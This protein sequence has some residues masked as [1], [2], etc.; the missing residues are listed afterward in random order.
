MTDVGSTKRSVVRAARDALAGIN[1]I[2]VGS[3][4]MAGSEKRGVEHARADL[5]DGAT[6][7]LTPDDET[8]AGAVADIEA[9]W[10]TL[11]MQTVR[12]S[13]EEHD[14]RISD[15]SHLPH[16]LAAALVVMQDPRSLAFAGKG[17]ED[18]TRIAAG[19]AGLWR[20]IFVDNRDNLRA[21]I[22][23]LQDALGD[24]LRHL[25]PGQDA[26]LHDWLVRAADK[27]ARSRNGTDR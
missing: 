16:A 3:H 26:A 12:M 22:S 10:R 23:Q 25:E 18:M 6:C 21:G 15:V 14:R 19:D 1:A 27:R 11:G 17:F 20:D 2:F 24:L 4:P 8:P 13:A 9:F 7:I 5:F